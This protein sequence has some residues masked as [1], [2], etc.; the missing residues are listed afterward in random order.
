M[1]VVNPR[2]LE[3]I[4]QSRAK[5]DKRDSYNLA[6]YLSKGLLLPEARMKGEGLSQLSSLAQTRDKLVESRTQLKNKLHALLS[7]T[8]WRAKGKPIRASAACSACRR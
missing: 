7:R 3:V 1:V 5:T 6:L 4:K 8:G 2:Q